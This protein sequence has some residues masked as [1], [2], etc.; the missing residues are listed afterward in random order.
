MRI[1]IALVVGLAGGFL[2]GLVLSQL[3][4][5]GGL[6]L[7]HQPLG[8]KFLPIYLAITGAV[9]APIVATRNRRRAQ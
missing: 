1:V 7:V 2:L 6:L 3:I 5:I 8:I 4:A 9:I